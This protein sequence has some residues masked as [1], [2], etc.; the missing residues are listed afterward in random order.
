MK[1]LTVI[2]VIFIPFTVMSGFFGMNVKVPFAAADDES[3]SILPF[4][5]IFIG[6]IFISVTLYLG[7]RWLKWL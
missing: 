6:C 1:G 5:L 4:F 3:D 7:F 2:T